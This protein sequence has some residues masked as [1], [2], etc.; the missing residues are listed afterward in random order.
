MNFYRN[1]NFIIYERAKNAQEVATECNIRYRWLCRMKQGD[2][3]NLHCNLF[4]DVYKICKYLD[5]HPAD[6]LFMDTID[7]RY[8]YL[9]PSVK[10][11]VEVNHNFIF[12]VKLFLNNHPS[13]TIKEKVYRAYMGRF[14][15]FSAKRKVQRMLGGHTKYT[16]DDVIK[17]SKVLGQEPQLMLFGVV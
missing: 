6:I 3:K 4:S 16:L 7:F 10:E 15:R 8:K 5:V 2:I 1:L 14:Y 9:D 17:I 12:N 11:Y 13:I